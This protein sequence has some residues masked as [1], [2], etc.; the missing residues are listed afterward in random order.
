MTFSLKY[1]GVVILLATILSGCGSSRKSACN[2]PQEEGAVPVLSFTKADA[3]EDMPVSESVG[4]H[5]GST[6]EFATNLLRKAAQSEGLKD[7]LVVSPLSAGYALS[8]LLEGATGQTREELDDMLGGS[9]AGIEPYTDEKTIVT[10]ASSVWLKD[11]IRILDSYEK[12]ISEKF[13]AQVFTRDFAS[14]STVQEINSW[15]SGHTAG[16]IPSI[17]G[18]IPRNSV[19]LLLNALYFKAPWAKPF[20]EDA[21]IRDTFHAVSGDQGNVSFMTRSARMN[22]MKGDSFG[23]LSLDYDKRYSMLVVLPDQG[24]D[25]ASVVEKLDA[26]T[27]SDV[28]DATSPRQVELRLP[29]FTVE[30]D[31]D[32]NPTLV[33]MG[34]KAAF[35]GGFGNMTNAPVAVSQVKQKCFV[36]V[37]EE[38]AEAAAVT[39][40]SM[41]LTS[42]ARPDPPVRFFVDRPFVFAIYDRQTKDIY[43]EGCMVKIEDKN[44]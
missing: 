32:L 1:P 14:R 24:K 6:M 29:R 41:R 26:G 39:S 9:F 36:K 38:G 7:N 30:T 19:M 10:T 8:L 27:L 5:E 22:Y 44:V 12:A 4:E 40:I 20:D 31:L 34:M 37:N 23:A 33:S 43:F 17:M 15:C 11:G 21:T 28:I 35:N 2:L 25:L 3:G 13:S 16:R 42:V 18:E